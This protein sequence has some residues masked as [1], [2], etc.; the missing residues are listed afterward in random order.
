MYPVLALFG[1]IVMAGIYGTAAAAAEI[2]GTS[3]GENG[4]SAL[5]V[6]PLAVVAGWQLLKLV[7]TPQYLD[8]AW[9]FAGMGLVHWPLCWVWAK[10][11]YHAGDRQAVT[12]ATL[13]S[14]GFTLI[15]FCTDWAYTWN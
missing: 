6:P 11:A 15:L 5:I 14:L 2:E 8:H 3:L 9:I 4:C 13:S 1:L 7:T 12:I 10:L